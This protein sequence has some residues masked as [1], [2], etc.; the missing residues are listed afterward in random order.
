MSSYLLEGHHSYHSNATYSPQM[1]TG[2]RQLKLILS[3]HVKTNKI[4]IQS[5]L[6]AKNPGNFS[7]K[8]AWVRK[9]VRLFWVKGFC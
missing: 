8:C 7:R 5:V 1:V 9:K 2:L 6:E 4:K 3:E